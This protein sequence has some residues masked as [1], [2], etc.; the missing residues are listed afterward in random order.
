MTTKRIFPEGLIGRKLGMTQVFDEEG[1]IVPVTILEMGPNVI[2]EVLNSERNGYNAVQLGFAPKKAQR[3]SK[4][5]MGQFNKAGKGAFYCVREMRCDV[6]T[7]GWN[8]LGQEL[9]VDDV[10]IDNEF[11]DV[12]GTSLGRGF[13]GV[14][15]RHHMKGQPMTRGTHEVRRHTGSIGM[16]KTPGRVFKNQRM[17]GHMGNAR[18][19]IQNLK[20]FSVRPEEGLIL[21][22]GNV[23]GPKGCFVEV[24]KSIKSFKGTVKRAPKTAPETNQE[25]V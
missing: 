8:A 4:P 15:K 18:V 10:F 25:A 16:R 2:L 9:N 20:V 6:E 21:V 13:A 7:L 19:T 5:E 11:V 23:P 3:V 12:T 24:R 1:A 17:P 14:F 22:R